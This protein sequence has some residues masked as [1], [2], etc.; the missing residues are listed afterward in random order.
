MHRAYRINSVQIPSVLLHQKIIQ[1]KIPTALPILQLSNANDTIRTHRPS[2]SIERNN[3]FSEF[4]THQYNFEEFCQI[5]FEF[6][7]NN[8]V[9]SICVNGSWIS[10]AALAT[11]ETLPKTNCRDA[12]NWDTTVWFDVGTST[13][14]ASSIN[15]GWIW[16]VTV[17]ST[18]FVWLRTDNMIFWMFWPAANTSNKLLCRYPLSHKPRWFN[19]W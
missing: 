16:L 13:I 18:L 15:R 3:F 5:N 17:F 14:L 4:R 12:I 1:R 19:V 7:R 9:I 8:V 6:T 11:Y 2:V 10:A